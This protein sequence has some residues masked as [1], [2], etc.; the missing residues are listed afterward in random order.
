M[1]KTIKIGNKEFLMSASAYTPF[2]YKNDTGRTLIKD[3][4]EIGKRYEEIKDLDIVEQYDEI[5]SFIM[6]ALRIAYIMSSESKGFIGSFDEFLMQI[7]DF[8]SDA[9]W[10]SEVVELAT[11]P[12]SGNLQNIQRN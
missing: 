9:N 4:M 8:L 6:L 11:S 12:I 1:K 7:D 3:L 10:V 2:K 5:D